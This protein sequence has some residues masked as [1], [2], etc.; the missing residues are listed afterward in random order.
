MSQLMPCRQLKASVFV[1]LHIEMAICNPQGYQFS[2]IA[3]G[4]G[5]MISA[6]FRVKPTY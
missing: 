6:V 1:N 5:P 3:Q 4:R 2:V